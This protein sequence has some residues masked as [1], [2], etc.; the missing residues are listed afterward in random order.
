LKETAW[1][2]HPERL[3]PATFF[4][5][6]TIDNISKAST[7]AAFP[8]Q[9]EQITKFM[10]FKKTLCLNGLCVKTTHQK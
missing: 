5:F 1:H 7:M 2:S 8:L 6:F 3:L 9:D 10:N 4:S